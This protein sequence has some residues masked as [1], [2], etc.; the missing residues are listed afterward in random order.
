LPR[1][2]LPSR[3]VF[4]ARP[5]RPACIEEPRRYNG[6]KRC[7]GNACS[8]GKVLIHPI[9]LQIVNAVQLLRLLVETLGALIVTVGVVVAVYYFL[10]ALF[11]RQSSN[12]GTIRLTF[13]R[14]LTLALEFQLGADILSTAIAPSWEQIGKLGAIAVIRTGLNFFL[15][16]ELRQDANKQGVSPIRLQDID[17]ENLP[18]P[19]ASTPPPL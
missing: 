17:A 2:A 8:R 4:L 16:L 10:Q 18:A 6:C 9:E 5:E 12:F 3:V 11:R 1:S 7:G 19:A 15:M 13:A 14:Y